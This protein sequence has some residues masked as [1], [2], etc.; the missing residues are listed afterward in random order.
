MDGSSAAMAGSR[1]NVIGVVLTMAL[2]GVACSGAS[3]TSAGSTEPT[4]SLS[5]SSSP[6]QTT[7][8]L[9]GCI[10]GCAAGNSIEP[11]GLPEGV[12]ETEWFFG[13]E[14]RLTFD[15]GWTSREDSTGEFQASPPDDPDEDVLFWEDVYPVEPPDGATTWVAADGV[16][17]IKGVPLTAAG[18]LDWMESSSQL[19]V[20]TPTPAAIGELPA[21]M[22]D[23]RVADDAV[24]DDPKNCPAPAC[25]N[26]IGFPQWDGPWGLAYPARFYLSDVRYGGRDHLLVV[27]IYP[28]RST[29]P[30]ILGRAKRLLST[31]RVPAE[32]A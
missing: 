12:Y 10:P 23:V 8:E 31:V 16:K 2:L 19:D 29:H 25:F 6:S 32:P 26:F 17:R 24:D 3:S 21:T 18:L 22:V 13:G 30:G 20:S 1:R 15:P 4:G 27:A 11:G 5:P 7:E 9:K 28:V 14:M